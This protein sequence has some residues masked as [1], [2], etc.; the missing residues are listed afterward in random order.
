MSLGKYAILPTSKQF[1][2]STAKKKAKARLA[3]M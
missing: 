2:K 3:M 1:L